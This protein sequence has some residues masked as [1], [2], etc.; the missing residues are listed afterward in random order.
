MS[1]RPATPWIPAD[2]ADDALPRSFPAKLLVLLA[3]RFRAGADPWI[4]LPC[5]LLDE[6]AQR[7]KGLVLQQAD[8]WKLPAA[9]VDWLHDAC[10]WRST[11][12][13][14]IV[15]APAEG[16]LL[17]AR[18]PLMAVAEPFAPLADRGRLS[19]AGF[20][21]HPAVQC[22]PRLEPFHLH[23]VRI[24]N[25]AHTALV[26]KAMPLG[27]Q[28]V[29]QA[30]EDPAVSAWLRALVF[31]EIVPVLEGRAGDAQGFAERTFERFANPFLEH[32][33]ADIALHHDVKLRTR[34]LPSYT[35]YRDRFG[36]LPKLLGEIVGGLA[37]NSP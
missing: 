3:H 15:S 21:K 33:L 9:L 24:L 32:R 11:L 18:D 12:V 7:L 31:E 27:F 29:R 23:K 34:L 22:V 8:L 30:I 25:G 5:E 2:R 13:D 26:A 4:I 6:N 20:E 37:G 14:R 17:A 16:D 19:A 10:Q 1:P 28:T 35:E 36:R